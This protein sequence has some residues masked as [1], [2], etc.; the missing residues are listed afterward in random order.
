MLILSS[1]SAGLELWSVNHTSRYEN[2]E[3]KVFKN[4]KFLG[5]MSK[6]SKTPTIKVKHRFFEN[7]FF[8][9]TITE[10]NDLDHLLCSAPSISFFKQNILKF[11]HLSP[12]K[13]F[14]IY[15]LHGLMLLARLALGLSHL[16]GHK[17]NQIFQWLSWWNLYVWKRYRI[18][19]PFPPPIFP[20]FL[21]KGKSSWIKFRILTAH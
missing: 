4:V 21:K 8:L 2:S 16:K 17:F 9:T 13:V 6:I 12:N 10:W 11:I 19:K 20:Y 14:S 3:S 18:Y 15:N 7:S 1:I 5:E